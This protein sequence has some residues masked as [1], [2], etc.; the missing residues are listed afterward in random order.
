MAENRM[1]TFL[2][3]IFYENPNH[4]MAI[5]KLEFHPSIL[6]KQIFHTLQENTFYS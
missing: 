3:Y 5:Q 4:Y 2:V 6:L 1:L